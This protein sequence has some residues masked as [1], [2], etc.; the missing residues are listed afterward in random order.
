ME[1]LGGVLKCLGVGSDF[2]QGGRRFGKRLEWV[3]S[4]ETN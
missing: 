2:S 4:S 3:C 1:V